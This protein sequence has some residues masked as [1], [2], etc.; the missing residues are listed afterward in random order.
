MSYENGNLFLLQTENYEPL[1]GLINELSNIVQTND[2]KIDNLAQKF[3]TEFEFP[4]YNF[5]NDNEEILDQR[6]EDVLHIFLERKYKLSEIPI[7]DPDIL[8]ALEEFKDDH[9][10]VGVLEDIAR[11]KSLRNINSY[12]NKE[13]HQSIKDFE[14]FISLTLLPN[15]RKDVE[16]HWLKSLSIIKDQQLPEKLELDSKTWKKYQEYVFYLDLL[17]KL[18]QKLVAIVH[19][20]SREDIMKVEAKIEI[21]NK[22]KLYVEN[23]RQIDD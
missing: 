15:F 1:F 4:N 16:A 12:K 10:V 6:Y 14:D 19:D 22:I 9:Y 8:S 21:V 17:I 7:E 5:S 2:Q 18:S 13:L 23:M 20:L 11:L 3:D